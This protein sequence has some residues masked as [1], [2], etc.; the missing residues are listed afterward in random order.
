MLG[1]AWL[2]LRQANEALKT[3]R[4]E[5]AHRLLCEPDA[6]GH[7]GTC[8]MLQQVARGF[9]ARGERNLQHDD[10]AAAWGDLQHAEQIGVA[11][12]GTA[13]LR[14][15]L[16]QRCL[17][18][19][20][21][22]LAAG[23]PG[24]AAEILSR[25]RQR[26]VQQPQLQLLAEAA[27]NWERAREL[28]E[29]GEF[30]QAIRSAA[31]VRQLL[32]DAPAPLAQFQQDL[33]QK[34]QAFGPLMI[35]LHEAVGKENWRDVVRLADQ[36]LALA[37]QQVEARKARGRAWKTIEPST[38]P[39]PGRSPVIPQPTPAEEPSPR[40]LLWI[41]GIGGY[42]ICLGTRVTIGQA[43]PETHVEIPLFA[44]V[45]RVHAALT[46]DTEGYLLEAMR[47]VKVNGEAAEKALLRPGDRVTLGGNCQ[48]Q[49]V[50]PVPVS[51][52]ARLD[53]VS[54]HRLPLAIDRVI[55]MADTLVLG[56]GAQSHIEVPDLQK[57][58]IL[59]RHKDGL[60]VRHTGNLTVDGQS[61]K[62][63]GTMGPN[64]RVAGDDFAF[65]VEPVG[66]TLGKMT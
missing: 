21:D 53:V 16:I 35:E 51:A 6:A 42:L 24:K 66:R 61:C 63:R 36:V 31:H 25:L 43:T 46:R 37:P 38:A 4:L 1:F 26:G 33:E 9:V 60:A 44:D 17:A 11:D 40:F 59:F 49:F 50:Q 22:I 29:H 58:V 2:T 12:G 47:P 18:D 34:N 28:A 27:K 45:S 13:K 52:T 56:P 30:A 14:Q 15:A 62:E 55:L 23:E 64:S 3:G 8:E 57:P 7:K 54:G 41:D 10:V 32:V 39:A 65:A 19:A 48:I 5:E 20:R